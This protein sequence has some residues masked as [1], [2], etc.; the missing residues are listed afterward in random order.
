MLLALIPWWWLFKVSL[1]DYLPEL[2]R[3]SCLM[4]QVQ[5]LAREWK[6]PPATTTSTTKKD[7]HPTNHPVTHI[8]RRVD[9]TR[10]SLAWI[11][12]SS[13]VEPL[14]HSVDTIFSLIP[15]K[16][17]NKLSIIRQFRRVVVRWGEEVIEIDRRIDRAR[18]VRGGWTRY[19]LTGWQQIIM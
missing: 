1:V 4:D 18:T 5:C 10:C 15:R 2:S 3:E 7:F 11:C 16:E 17:I 9:T 6:A 19:L 13:S 14:R 8:K 12:K